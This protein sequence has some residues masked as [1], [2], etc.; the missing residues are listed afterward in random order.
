MSWARMYCHF[1]HPSPKKA[2]SLLKHANL[3]KISPK[4][5]TDLE[6]IPHTCEVYQSES[7]ASQR[8]RVALPDED[9]IF[10]WKVWLDLMYI[11]SKTIFHA[12]DKYIKGKAA[13]FLERETA[14]AVWED[15]MQI[16]VPKMYWIFWN[17]CCRLESSIE[18]KRMKIAHNCSRYKEVEFGGWKLQCAASRW[19]LPWFCFVDPL[20]TLGQKSRTAL[21]RQRSV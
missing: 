7:E 17:Y 21:C 18:I 11:H 2:F 13:K 20:K 8:L 14:A 12:V 3:D 19:T 5:S 15:F 16:W 4:T 10:S 1:H 6:K 9:L